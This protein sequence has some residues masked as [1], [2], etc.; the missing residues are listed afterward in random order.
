M[1]KRHVPV[2]VIVVGL[3]LLGAGCV[4][5]DPTFNITKDGLHFRVRTAENSSK[6]EPPA[7]PEPPAIAEANPLAPPPQPSQ[8]EADT[9]GTNAAYNLDVPSDTCPQLHIRRITHTPNSTI[10]DLTFINEGLAPVMRVRTG[11]PGQQTAFTLTDPTSG[12]VYQLQNVEGISLDPLWTTVDEGETVNFTLTF[13]R[14]PDDL[15]AFRLIEGVGDTS[16]QGQIWSFSNVPLPH[17]HQ[18]FQQL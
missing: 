1:K 2:G 8:P 6:P 17:S 14:L 15:T 18:E 9:W 4:N 13:E 10:I 7:A 12:H 11:A 3:A 5:T 16:E